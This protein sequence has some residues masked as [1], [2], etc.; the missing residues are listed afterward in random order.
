M[1][2]RVIDN[3]EFAHIQNERYL[4]SWSEAFSAERLF[5]APLPRNALHHAKRGS[6]S[7]ISSR[8]SL[9]SAIHLNDVFFGANASS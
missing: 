6:S 9:A 5:I 1:N 4:V 8:L 2:Q 3:E 7:R